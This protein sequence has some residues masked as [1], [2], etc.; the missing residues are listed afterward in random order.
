[1]PLSPQEGNGCLT[2]SKCLIKS[3]C[4]LF[5][6]KTTV[7]DLISTV[8]MIIDYVIIITSLYGT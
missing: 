3:R 8:S 6:N 1:M 4:I 5:M 7:V 2:P